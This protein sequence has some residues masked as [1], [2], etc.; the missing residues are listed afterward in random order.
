MYFEMFLTL[1]SLILLHKWDFIGVY[2]QTC[3]LSHCRDE[4]R[5][6]EPLIPATGSSPGE[7]VLIE[8][9]ESGTPDDVLN[10]KKKIWEKLQ[11][12]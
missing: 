7:R 3:L 9:Y 2:H 4:P 11:V 10:P 1:F 12:Q 5:A 8:G 6:V